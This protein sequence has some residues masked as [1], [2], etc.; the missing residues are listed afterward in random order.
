MIRKTY[1]GNNIFITFWVCIF[2]NLKHCYQFTERNN[3]MA[4]S[5]GFRY[6][7]RYKIDPLY[8]A[9][10][11]IDELV[12]FCIDARAEEVMMFMFAEE[13]TTGHPTIEELGPYVEM[14]KKLKSK[15]S[16][17]NI[18]ISLNP[19]T[20]TYHTARGRK[21][22]PGQN[23][24]LMIRE[25]GTD[26]GITACPLCPQWQKYICE[27][28]AYLAREVK[29]VAIWIED[30]WRLHNHGPK[31]GWGGCFCDLHLER[32]A[33]K[34][35]RKVTREELMEKIL[36]EGEPDPWREKWIDVCRDS[37]IEPAEKLRKAVKQ[38]NPS[39]RL[40]L[41]SSSPDTHSIEGR[42]WPALQ[43][44]LGDNPTFIIRPHMSP[45]TET[46][47]INTPPSVT[48]HTIANLKGE[49]EIYPELENSPRV[50]QYSKSGA[51]N[52]WQCLNA[53]AFG[54]DGITI[55][56]F[57]MMGTGIS[58]DPYIAKFFAGAKNRL[59]AIAKLGIDDRQAD[60]VR[61]L[62]N[63]NIARYIHSKE[64]DTMRG[65]TNQSDMWSKTLSILGV[66]HRFANEIVPD[67]TPYAL[68]DQTLR[69]FSDEQIEKLLSCPV[70][71]DAI[72]IEVLVERGFGKLI[73]IEK[74]RWAR[75]YEDVYAYESIEEP[76]PQIYG[77][78]YPR[79]TAQ[80]CTKQLIDMK[81]LENA[82]IL[83]WICNPWHKKLFPGAVLFENEAG[84]KI[85][86]I[87][88]PLLDEEQF[89]MGFF[90]I[91]RRTMI[92]RV[93]FNQLAPRA[94]LAGCVNH[95]AFCYRAPTSRGT[96]IA[97]INILLDKADRCILQIPADQIDTK[98]IKILND[99]GEWK[100][101]SIEKI[102]KDGIDILTIEREI[103]PLDG[104]FLLI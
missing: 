39:T 14:L 46:P 8:Y 27:V 21:L 85:F 78:P 38:A 89:F 70:L 65:L 29:P 58:L 18:D 97:V 56:H 6:I 57:D 98:N 17:H 41:M 82:Q 67:G 52:I 63:P 71:L 44:S 45:Y 94:R 83:S 96:F 24:T 61:V 26:N 34:V 93:L 79:M 100:P 60:G 48:R 1:N 36:A 30:D 91:Y 32:F 87:A 43:K 28:F 101:L 15:L 50:G 20:T 81:P 86:S 12:Q 77:L 59:N 75:L 95:P 2:Y 42:D 22:K 64:S 90:G 99:A 92:Q 69:A 84:G 23:F 25:D 54:S 16:Q 4:N 74:N 76:D 13:L 68:S 9:D 49:L 73:G 47:A 35:G 19:W 66:A 55:N 88:Y 53:A 103:A 3:D 40:A 5:D 31:G 11:R 33:E 37:L 62:F 10:Q 72:S 7:F 102:T 104:I 80:R 51:Y